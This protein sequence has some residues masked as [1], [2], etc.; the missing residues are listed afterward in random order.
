MPKLQAGDVAPGLALSDE[1]GS[2]ITLDDYQGKR[3]VVYFYPADDTPGCTK[4]A[5]QFSDLFD[6]FL[7]AGVDVIGI[8]PDDESSHRRFREKFGL[9]VR[10]LSD[11]SHSV[12]ESY[13]AWGEKTL[14][15]KRS[16]GVIRTTVLVGAE[17]RIERAWY[18]VRADG[19]AAKVLAAVTA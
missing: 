16:V 6:E 10:L 2:V 7:A 15:G 13:G 11:P 18:H 1:D 17:G 19:H 9:T 14:Y 5:C 8:S 3:V 4:E 12:M